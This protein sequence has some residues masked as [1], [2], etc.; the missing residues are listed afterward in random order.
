MHQINWDTVTSTCDKGGLGI[1]N[2]R[3]M[4]TVLLV[5]WIVGIGTKLID[6]GG[7]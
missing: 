6:F 3:D 1:P 4:N 5:K 7:E 2:L